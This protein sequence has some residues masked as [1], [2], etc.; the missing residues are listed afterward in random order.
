MKRINITGAKLNTK[1]G[2]D[3][4][5]NFLMKNLGK[6]WMDIM[7]KEPTKVIKLLQ[8]YYNNNNTLKSHYSRISKFLKSLKKD[9]NNSVAN[10][11]IDLYMQRLKKYDE[12]SRTERGMNKKKGKEIEKWTSWHN[13]L[14]VRNFLK[15]KAKNYNTYLDYLIICLYT[16]QP[17]LRTD[18]ADMIV[19]DKYPKINFKEKIP[20]EKYEDKDNIL[21]F[22]KKDNSEFIL[23][24]FKTKKFY[25]NYR[26]D[27]NEKL[28]D[29][30]YVWLEKYNKKSK[31]LLADENGNKISRKKL[32][33]M[34]I[35]I[36]SNT[37]G[38]NVSI[39][40]LRQIFISTVTH[41]KDITYN[42]RKK[43]ADDMGHSV[44]QQL[45]YNKIDI[46]EDD[47]DHDKIKEIY[48]DRY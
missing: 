34:V 4:T 30:I 27:L 7:I 12:L 43:L 46:E 47:I 15:S 36:F 40:T 31:Y 3:A 35:D 13:V 1:K 42:Q 33:Q 18:Y 11:V 16:Y 20:E 23:T 37:I 10:K 26:I 6:E 32:S 22:D 28:Y 41:R 29:I 48:K 21:F 14:E 19:V 5:Q 39:T 44:E 9:D 38:K 24:N 45:L 25:G 17:P 2:Y 8:S